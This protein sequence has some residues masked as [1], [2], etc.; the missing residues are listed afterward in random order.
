M[1]DH[2]TNAIKQK[3]GEMISDFYKVGIL[4]IVFPYIFAFGY[5]FS[6]LRKRKFDFQETIRVLLCRCD[7]IA[8]R[9]LLVIM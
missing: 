8:E 7:N 2:L 9:N 1:T 3:S 5:D 4:T 6:L